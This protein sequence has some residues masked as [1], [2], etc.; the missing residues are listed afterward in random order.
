L[1]NAVSAR[2]QASELVG[3]AERYEVADDERLAAVANAADRFEPIE[4]KSE[5]AE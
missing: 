1:A 3:L 2:P 4:V 5:A